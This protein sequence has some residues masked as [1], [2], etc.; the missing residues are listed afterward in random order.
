MPIGYL[1]AVAVAAGPVLLAVR[2]LR[3]SGRLGRISWLGSMVVN[4]SPFL[5]VYWVVAATL[6]AL[7]QHDLATPV[8]WLALGLACVTV[9]A[10]PVLVTRSMR[11]RP[12]VERALDETYGAAWRSRVGPAPRTPWGR[13]LLAPLPL[14]PRGIERISNL[15]YGD[16]GR[17]NRLDVYRSRSRPTSGPILIHLHGGGF[18]G[19]R[20]SF[21]GRPLVHRFARRGWV[22]ISANY[23][24]RPA[25]TFPDYLVDAKKVIAWARA[26]AGELGADPSRVVVAGDSAGAHLA[27][28]TALTAGDPRFQPG[29]EESDTSV[30]AA[31]GLYGY[32]GPVD[33]MRQPLPSAPGNYAHDGAPPILIAHGDQDTLV[34]PVGPQALVEKLRAVS[35]GPIVYVE[36]P[37]AQHTFDLLHSI[38]CEALVDGI[39][40]FVKL[41]P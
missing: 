18:R 36:L 6:L 24:L 19:G 5:A 37:G 32:Y 33:A 27:V 35:A 20:K 28:T 16:A 22:C 40:A 30:A 1:I 41:L 29:F 2:P 12:A 13:I 11:A 38:R 26:H 21:E 15:S 23:Q 10:L 4:E 8:G 34:P 31:V 7:A 9:V 25:A 14:R 39:E 17:L 3:R